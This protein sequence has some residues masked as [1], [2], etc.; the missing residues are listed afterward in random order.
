MKYGYRLKQ[1]ETGFTQA[2]GA[3]WTIVGWCWMGWELFKVFQFDII[4]LQEPSYIA[5]VLY[6]LRH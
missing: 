2:L 4:Y 3:P 6:V 1:E 5:E